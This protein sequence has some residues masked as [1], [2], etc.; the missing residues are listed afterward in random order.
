[1]SYISLNLEIL[2]LKISYP[3]QYCQEYCVELLYKF[4]CYLKKN[5]QDDQ[6]HIHTYFKEASQDGDYIQATLQC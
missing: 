3:S 1:M 4:K 2:F 5:R 6:T